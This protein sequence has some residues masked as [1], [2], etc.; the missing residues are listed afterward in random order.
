VIAMTVERLSD[1]EY[2]LPDPDGGDWFV[3]R[4]PSGAGWYA[5]CPDGHDGYPLRWEGWTPHDP[6]NQRLFP[7]PADAIRAVIGE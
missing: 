1:V 5:V 6:D 2:R 4:H 7:T 3:R